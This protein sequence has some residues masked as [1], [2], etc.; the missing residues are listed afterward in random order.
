MNIKELCL[1]LDEFLQVQRYRDYAPNG[2]QVQGRETVERIVSGVSASAQLIEKAIAVN[3]D[4]LL[5]HHGYFWKNENPRIVGIKA[6]R[7]K[8][9]LGHDIN[10]L[11]YHLPLDGHP[12]VGNNAQ[13]GLLLD[14][15]GIPLDKDNLAQGLVW[16]THLDHAVP[17]TQFRQLVADR[18]GREPLHIAGGG[19]EIRHVAWCS[20]AAQHHIQD[21]AGH[22]VD[23]YISGEISEPTVHAAREYGMHYF[24]AGHHAT[25]RYGVKA[26]GQHLADKFEIY[27]QFIDI[28]NPV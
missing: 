17:V 19:D 26:L 18:L 1:Y 15:N 4:T 27:H 13:L 28:D 21:V 10:L 7:L 8:A 20:G 24:A 6:A 12:V 11:A 23:L 2:L 14:L 9:L 22:H 16:H 5:V 25:E 3:A